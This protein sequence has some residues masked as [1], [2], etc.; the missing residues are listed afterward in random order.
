MI[1]QNRALHRLC[2]ATPGEKV[3]WAG[4]ASRPDS[5]ASRPDSAPPFCATEAVIEYDGPCVQSEKHD[6]CIFP[7]WVQRYKRPA[8]KC[9]NKLSVLSS[10]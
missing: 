10:I 9:T 6:V 1:K 8:T 4:L 7:G 5:A 3:K 2:R